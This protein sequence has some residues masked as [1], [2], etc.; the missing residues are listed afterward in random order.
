MT[1]TALQAGKI[2]GER[3]TWRL[4]N[5]EMQKILYLAHMVHLG[6]HDAKPLVTGYFE[7]WDY[8]PVHPDLYHHVKRFG[9]GAVEDVFGD[10]PWAPHGTEREMLESAVDELAEVRSSRLVAITHWEGGAWAH[11]YNPG[12]R[13]RRIPN[14]AILDEYVRRGN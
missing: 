4:S 11:H 5:L 9:A 1:I 8:G 3:S 6:K 13:G 7:A 2:M 10:I 12:F 14:K